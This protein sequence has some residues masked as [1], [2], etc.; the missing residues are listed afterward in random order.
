MKVI[1]HD[2]GK[3]SD[4]EGAEHGFNSSELYN[5]KMSEL[6]SDVLIKDRILQAVQ[7]HSV[8]DKDCP[9]HVKQ[10]IIWKVLKDADALDRS[11]FA[12]KGCDKSYL[13]LDIYQSPSGQNIFD[14]ASYLPGW[15]QDIDKENIYEALS[16]QVNT[17]SNI[18][19]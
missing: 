16:E 5:D 3:R 19:K 13:R 8:E 7:F 12:G 4:R 2:L 11:R 10:D 9:N 15:I 18:T 1:I 14:L 17:Y 6:I